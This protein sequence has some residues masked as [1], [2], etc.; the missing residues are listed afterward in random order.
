MRPLQEAAVG[1]GTRQV[2][3]TTHKADKTW[4]T[5]SLPGS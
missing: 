1:N 4:A 5:T 3:K 2:N